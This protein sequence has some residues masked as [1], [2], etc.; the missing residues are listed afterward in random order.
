M[1]KRHPI[2]S[3]KRAHALAM[4]AFLLGLALIVFY[5]EW[6]WPG[7]ML[8]I[9]LPLALRHYLL[10]HT[11]DM[12]VALLIFGGVFVS[13]AFNISWNGFFPTMLIVGALYILFR[14]F[15]GPDDTT[16]D[17]REEEINREI[18]ERD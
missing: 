8:V 11:Y 10:G 6:F 7:I 12:L 14:E 15:F 5:S 1:T 18:A 2:T 13:T 3:A 16:E 9:G 4:A 17:E